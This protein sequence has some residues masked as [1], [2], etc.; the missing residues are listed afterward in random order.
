VPVATG[1]ARHNSDSQNRDE[2]RALPHMQFSPSASH[3]VGLV[4]SQV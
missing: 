1:K 4:Q 2:L 3:L